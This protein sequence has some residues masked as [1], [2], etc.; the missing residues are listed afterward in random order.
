MFYAV[1]A[2][3]LAALAVTPWPIVDDFIRQAD[4]KPEGDWL[5][6]CKAFTPAG[7]PIHSFHLTYG[8]RVRDQAAHFRVGIASPDRIT[9]EEWA[10]VEEAAMQDWDLGA[11]ARKVAWELAQR[12][13]DLA[14]RGDIEIALMN[15]KTNQFCPSRPELWKIT[16]RNAVHR[17]ATC[18]LS[19]AEPG[20]GSAEPTHWIFVSNLRLEEKLAACAYDN[21]M[22]SMSVDFRMWREIDEPDRRLRE[23]I[24]FNFLRREMESGRDHWRRDDWMKAIEAAF[25]AISDRDYDALRRRI[26]KTDPALK[27][28]FSK[29]GP[30]RR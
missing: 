17:L 1:A 23:G 28:R 4:L 15:V 22:T 25:G 9:H 2:D 30:K 12:L 5:P 16:P 20:D 10:A 19:V 26:F 21:Y 29:S 7:E 11:G 24:L 8:A 14:W 3:R 27:A 13:A 6:S 18:Q